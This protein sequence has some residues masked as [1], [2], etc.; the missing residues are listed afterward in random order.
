M[1]G[2]SSSMKPLLALPLLAFCACS[3]GTDD[4]GEVWAENTF[5]KPAARQLTSPRGWPVESGEP[6][7]PRPFVVLE[8]DY[9]KGP[10]DYEGPSRFHPLNPA[11][12][13][14]MI[15]KSAEEVRSLVWV[16]KII[17]KEYKGTIQIKR[18]TQ[19]VFSQEAVHLVQ[20]FVKDEN[21]GFVGVADDMFEGHEDDDLRAYLEKLPQAPPE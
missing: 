18:R 17:R 19:K 20:V 11:L 21:G 8:Y 12:P 5:G 9:S 10:G 4:S 3:G 2:Y 15:A 6:Y 1:R 13:A 14:S 16:R 7:A